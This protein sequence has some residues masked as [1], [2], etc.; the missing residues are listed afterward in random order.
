[1]IRRALASWLTGPLATGDAVAALLPRCERRDAI[2]VLG[3]P[4]TPDGQPSAVVAERVAV[5]AAL[6]HAG[7]AAQVIVTGG[8]TRGAPRSEAAA[9][10]AA[11]RAAEVDPAAIDPKRQQELEF[12]EERDIPLSRR[13]MLFLKY[14]HG[15]YFPWKV[16][17]ELMPGGRWDDKSDP[18]GK[19]FTREAMKLFPR[20]IAFIKSLPFE[21]L[22][23]VKLLGLDRKSVV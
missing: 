9:M 20:T 21:Y 4:L 13:Q 15:V 11:L 5:A 14:R 8:R 23:S 12:G 17:V 3:A 7:G 16:Y 22:G 19:H 18:A 1:M 10:A 6:W 2:V